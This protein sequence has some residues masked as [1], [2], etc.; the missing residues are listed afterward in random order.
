MTKAQIIAKAQL[1]IGDMSDLSDADIS[2]LFDK[3][4]GAI[5]AARPWEF[6]KT[7]CDF[8]Q[9]TSV[10]YVALPGDFMYFVLDNNHS[11]NNYYGEGPKVFVGPNNAVIDIVSYSDRRQY[12]NDPSKA[13][14]DIANQRLVFCQQ[15]TQALAGSFDYHAVPAT[16]ALTASPIF[17]AAYH[18]MIYHG[19]VADD[20]M[21]QLFD[22]AKSYR[23]E[24]LADYNRYMKKLTSYNFN[25]VQQN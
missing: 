9:S 10:P 15:P 14:L 25:L 16:L 22:K 8:T 17:P 19:M 3:I 24:N 4:Y 6:T 23:D 2:D 11:T 1:Y 13:Y 7:E 5:L 12:A 20:Y 21:V 18:D